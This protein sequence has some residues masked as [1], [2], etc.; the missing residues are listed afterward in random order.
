MRYLVIS[1]ILCLSGCAAV[2]V[3]ASFPAAPAILMERC[4]ELKTIA[5]DQVSIVDFV[6]TVTENYTAYYECSAKN[7]AWQDWYTQQKKIWEQTQ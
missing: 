6:K 3:T 5:K 2:P 7:L 4:P 1:L